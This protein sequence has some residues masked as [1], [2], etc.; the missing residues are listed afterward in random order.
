VGWFATL[1]GARWGLG[2]GGIAAL[3]AALISLVNLCHAHSRAKDSV[4]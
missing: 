3:T 1:A 4:E 2:L